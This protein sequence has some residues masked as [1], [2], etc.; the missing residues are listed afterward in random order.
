MVRGRRGRGRARAQGRAA[1]L[2]C[3][4]RAVHTRRYAAPA[5]GS[6]PTDKQNLVR[7]PVES[8]SDQDFQQWVDSDRQ[9]MLMTCTRMYMAPLRSDCGAFTHKITGCCY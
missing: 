7:I 8:I 3:L 9:F 6:R 2:P 1:W 4:R 5:L